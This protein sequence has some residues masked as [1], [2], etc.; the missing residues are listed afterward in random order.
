V[1]FR[2]G[3]FYLMLTSLSA[4]L[5]PSSMES[6]YGLFSLLW[7]QTWHSFG[8]KTDADNH[9]IFKPF[10]PI[11]KHENHEHLTIQNFYHKV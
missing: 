8:V 11:P 2:L 10:I 5:N 6:T 9:E 3:D 7:I 4:I 1:N